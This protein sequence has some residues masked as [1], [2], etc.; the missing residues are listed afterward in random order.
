MVPL[1]DG[2]EKTYENPM[3]QSAHERQ[4]HF[5]RYDHIRYYGSDIRNRIEKA[6]FDIYEYTADGLRSVKCGLIRGDKVF[7]CSKKPKR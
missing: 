4:H 3:I 7:V 5:G 1:I 2:W 6:G